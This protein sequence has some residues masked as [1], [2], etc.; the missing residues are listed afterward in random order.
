MQIRCGTRRLFPLLPGAAIGALALTSGCSGSGTPSQAP[1]RNFILRSGAEARFGQ[2]ARIPPRQL[3][4]GHT[5]VERDLFVSN[6]G[7][8]VIVLKNKSYQR[9]GEITKGL[10]GADGLWVDKHGNLYVANYNGYNVTEYKRGSSVPSCTYSKGLADPIDVT[11]DKAGNVYV[12]NASIYP[13]YPGYI[14]E[15]PQC[16]NS[17]SKIYDDTG[18][19]VGIAVDAQGDVFVSYLI[20]SQG[21]FEEFKGG[22]VQPTSLRA[23][24]GFAGGLV[25]DNRSNLIAVDQ[26]GS[27]VVIAPP[28][29]RAKLLVGG[30][31]QP[32]HDA[33]NKR[34]NRL[35]VTDFASSTVSVFEYPSGRLITTLGSG[36]GIY[37]AAGVAESPNAV[38]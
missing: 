33:L 15:Y 2:S 30:L 19:P 34:E 27:I 38:F 6:D 10:N 17:V 22:S 5:R 9:S 3:F 31:S 36:N 18:D 21:F 24:V 1:V 7:N 23:T 11:T 8:G 4:L 37:G 16:R 13:S 25:L 12:A 35:F 26:D 20:Q 29:D 32:F 14:Y 28:Y